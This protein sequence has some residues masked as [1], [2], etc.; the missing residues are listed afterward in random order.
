MSERT[1]NFLRLVERSIFGYSK[2]PYR[3]LLEL[4]G[5]ELG[6]IRNLVQTR[7]LEALKRS[8]VAAH[9]AG[10]LWKKAETIRVRRQEPILTAG[11]KFMPLRLAKLSQSETR[12]EA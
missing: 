11:G 10:E 1:A 8:S 5:C 4:A 2:S 3:P 6:D 9:L 7:G 12:E